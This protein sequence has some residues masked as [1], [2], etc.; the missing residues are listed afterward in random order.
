MRALR[1]HAFGP[2]D[3]HLVETCTRPEPGP[4][5][6]LVRVSAAG[7]NFYDALIIQG[8]YQIKPGLPFSPGG[9]IAGEIEA[10]G[11]GVNH[12]SLG[13]RVCAFT[14][15]VNDRDAHWPNCDSWQ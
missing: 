6:V 5:E 14:I 8:R 9:E 4:G 2:I 3:S 12:L 1:C 11:E 7:V 10:V 13:Q 15:F